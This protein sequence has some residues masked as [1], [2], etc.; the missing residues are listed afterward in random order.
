MR[1]LTNTSFYIIVLDYLVQPGA[2]TWSIQLS[3]WDNERN[4]SQNGLFSE[5]FF[6]GNRP[7]ELTGSKI[8][9]TRRKNGGLMRGRLHI[10]TDFLLLYSSIPILPFLTLHIPLL[11][12]GSQLTY[13]LDKFRARKCIFWTVFLCQICM[14]LHGIYS[15][16]LLTKREVKM[17]GYWP[18]SFVAFLWSETNKPGARRVS[19]VK[20]EDVFHG[21]S[22]VF[23]SCFV[24][25]SSPRREGRRW[26]DK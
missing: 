20:R 26:M 11:V 6:A 15:Y 10:K 25:I 17:A 12:K 4:G 23:V 3:Y 9:E 21:R 13:T 24:F 1:T 16:A 5:Y 8:H 7:L 14:G 22:Q 2:A 18:G 19:L